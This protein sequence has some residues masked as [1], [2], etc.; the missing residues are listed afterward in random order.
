MLENLQTLMGQQLMH[1]RNM[2]GQAMFENWRTALSVPY[3]C[4]R[5]ESST[6][7]ICHPRCRPET[8]REPCPHFPLRRQS[9]TLNG[10]CSSTRWRTLAVTSPSRRS[11]W[12]PRYENSGT[13]RR[14][15]GWITETTVNRLFGIGYWVLGIC[16]WC[17]VFCVL[18][19]VFCNLFVI[20][21]L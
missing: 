7:T 6:V 10:K 8:N 15:L 21:Y 20:C 17:L 13:K 18:C 14:N 3:S 16:V 19:F 4:A 9:K 11:Y 2:I 1:L 12:K 5:K